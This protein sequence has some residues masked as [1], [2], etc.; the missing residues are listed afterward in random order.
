MF[1]KI[2]VFMFS[3]IIAGVAMFP[4]QVKAEEQVSVG[5]AFIEAF[6]KKDEAAMA[7]IIK[8]R[9]AEVPEEVK[10]MVEYAVSPGAN[11]QEQDFLFN[12]A[13]TMAQ[14]YAKNTGDERLLAAV[15]TNYQSVIDKRKAS[16]GGVSK[17]VLEKIKKDL[18]GL[19]KGEWRV[20]VIRVDAEGALDVEIDVKESS[21]GE[22]LTPHIER[23]KSEEAKKIVAK[24]LPHMKKG[25]LVWT[26]AGVG[27]KTSF[28]E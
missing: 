19:G 5:N 26:S 18:E 17:E 15:R 27:L 10:G 28:I 23:S 4:G 1:N 9:A 11:P 20:T 7:N 12:I 6:D 2:A 3:I 13:G 21:G 16:G 24:H 8:T 14:M 22:S 25:K